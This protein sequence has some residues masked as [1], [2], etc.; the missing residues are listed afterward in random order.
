MKSKR[1]PSLIQWWFGPGLSVEYIFISKDRRPQNTYKLI[2]LYFRT[3]LI[4]PIK[5]RIA[6]LYVLLLQKLFGLTV[7]AITGSAGK[8]STKD[9]IASI[10]NQ[11]NRTVFSHANITP[12]F[13]IPTTILQCTRKTKYLVLEMGVEYPGDMDFYLWLVKPNVGIITNIYQTHTEYFKDVEGVSREK[14]K[15][16][17]ALDSNDFVILNKENEHLKS[18]ASKLKSQLVWFGERGE[19]SASDEKVSSDGTSF[20]LQIGHTKEEIHLSFIG[21]QFVSNSLA[22][23][24]G[25]YAIGATVQEIKGGLEKLKPAEHRMNL[26]Y[27]KS[28]AVIL[29]DTYNSNPSA[30]KKALE[31]LREISGKKQT[32]AVLGDMLELGENEKEIHKE[33]G[34]YCSSLGINYV[35]GVGNLA[36][37]V[38]G[39]FYKKSEVSKYWVPKAENSYDLLKPFLKKNVVVLIKGSR[40]IG[41]DKLVAKL[42]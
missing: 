31:T 16:V 32:V 34:K 41:L 38:V 29:D 23:V 5:R 10:L 35:L 40:S 8:T 39:E 30:A 15:L 11:K 6:K 20:T 27:L 21:K 13:N 2:R 14:T 17:K 37:N 26:L 7:I 19:V 4:H 42:A 33:L 25:A 18:I 24:A 28:G 36:Q 9:M 22:A 12:T 1:A 3:W